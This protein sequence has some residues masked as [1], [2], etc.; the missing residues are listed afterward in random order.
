MYSG[1]RFSFAFVPVKP[2]F[3]TCTAV[4]P[5]VYIDFAVVLPKADV[6]NVPGQRGSLSAASY[7]G[8][9]V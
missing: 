3:D 9:R 8:R 2:Q 6:S 7:F 1:R 4:Q 5:K